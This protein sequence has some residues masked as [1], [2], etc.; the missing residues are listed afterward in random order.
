[1]GRVLGRMSIGC[2][3]SKMRPGS[4]L[5]PCEETRESFC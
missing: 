3:G 2:V 4:A 1:M 5:S